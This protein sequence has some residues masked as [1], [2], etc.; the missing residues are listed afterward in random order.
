MG[1]IYIKIIQSYVYSK[2]KK[3]N[4][5][6]EIYKIFGLP[7]I[8]I[9]ILNSILSV[10]Y[11]IF[12][13]LNDFVTANKI[14]SSFSLLW[15]SFIYYIYVVLLDIISRIIIYKISIA[16]NVK[17]FLKYYFLIIIIIVGALYISYYLSYYII[18]FYN[19]YNFKTYI[20]NDL[21][22]NLH[23]IIFITSILPIFLLIT[24]FILEILFRFI[25]YPLQLIVK[26][27]FTFV[28]NRK[29]YIV[30]IVTLILML[31]IRFTT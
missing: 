13:H 20:E 22:I 23:L 24:I 21:N 12:I 5:K 30:L 8:Y 26:I 31:F 14:L 28:I 10:L 2:H 9:F 15:L 11:L 27:F 17:L 25:L 18:V 16:N 1:I 4:L 7:F 3:M 19:L 29:L 6:S